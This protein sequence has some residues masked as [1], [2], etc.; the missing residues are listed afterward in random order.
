MADLTQEK[1]VIVKNKAGLHARPASSIVLA[2]AASDCTVQISN[3]EMG[4]EAN[5]E[6]TMELLFL[7]AT[8]GTRLHIKATGKD[9]DQLITTLAGLFESGFGED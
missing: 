3:P 9:S 6:S 4:K 2:V 1:D 5:G 7:S 8:V